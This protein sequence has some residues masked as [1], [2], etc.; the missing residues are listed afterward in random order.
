MSLK[1]I[2][3]A[4][5]DFRHDSVNSKQLLHKYKTLYWQECRN[6]SKCQKELRNAKSVIEGH[7]Q[8]IER[9]KKELKLLRKKSGL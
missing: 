8:D 3:S 6:V 9:L 2:E 5:K 4:V 1:N 7:L